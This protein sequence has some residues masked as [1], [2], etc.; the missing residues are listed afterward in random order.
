MSRTAE[1][2]DYEAPRIEDHGGLLELTAGG[3]VGKV[4]DHSFMAH[5][6]EGTEHDLKSTP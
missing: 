2:T 3:E 6:G 5:K 4:Y 1:T